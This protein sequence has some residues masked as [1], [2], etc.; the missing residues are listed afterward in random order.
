MN[1]EIK[2]V[3]AY[4]SGFEGGVQAKLQ[5]IR[6]MILS[7]APGAMESILYGMPAYKTHDKPLAYFGGFA[8]HIG[9]YATPAGHKKFEKQRSICQQGKGSAQFPSDQ[10]LPIDL[11]AEIVTFRDWEN[12][13]EV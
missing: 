5:R 12:H 1:K 7:N 13:Q 4:I 6:H 8:N 3:D 11:I 2:T 9:I 10:T